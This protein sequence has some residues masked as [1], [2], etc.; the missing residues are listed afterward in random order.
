MLV[1]LRESI[2]IIESEIEYAKTVN[3]QMALGMSQVKQLIED[4]MQ[5][6]LVSLIL[7]SKKEV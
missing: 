5:R 6:E 7:E 1:G 2:A 3:Q 4:R